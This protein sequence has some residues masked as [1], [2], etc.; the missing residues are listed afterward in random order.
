[1]T[2]GSIHCNCK[3]VRATEGSHVVSWSRSL[4]N[5]TMLRTLGC[6]TTRATVSTARANP[7]CYL[8]LCN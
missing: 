5:M 8:H 1:M 7:D 2:N 6:N 4:I 3:K